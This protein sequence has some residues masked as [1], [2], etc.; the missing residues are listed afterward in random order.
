MKITI[1]GYFILFLFTVITSC[2]TD[3]NSED[4]PVETTIS[5]Q[6]TH[7][8]DDEQI[9]SDDFNDIKFVNEGQQ[10]MSIELLRYLVS[11]ITFENNK[12]EI[13]NLENYHLIDFSY[14]ESLS[15]VSSERIP[16]GEYKNVS[17]TFGFDNED[18]QSGIYADLNTALWNVPEMMG[19]GYHYMQLEGK[20]IDASETET[21]YQFHTIRAVDN[22]GDEMLFQDTF[23]TVDLGPLTVAENQIFTVNMNVAEW[24]KDPNE[25]NLNE[26]HSM[27]MPNFDAQVMMYE[28]GQDVFELK[29]E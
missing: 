1:R 14:E 11:D 18:N 23:F 5:F 19:G 28:N 8:W 25:W 20:F 22:S 26:L 7:S 13:I 4:E 12:G 17:F 29:T 21:G 27:L 3:N 2:S 16:V 24:F 15:L 9:T 6:F 10:M